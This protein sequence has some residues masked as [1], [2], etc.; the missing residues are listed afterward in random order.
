MRL[1]AAVRAKVKS[2]SS[3][4]LTLQTKGASNTMSVH[5]IV[6]ARWQTYSI[7][8]DVPPSAVTLSLGGALIGDGEACFDDFR[9]EIVPPGIP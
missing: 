8:L 5:P 4:R 3:A 7:D 9:L 1:T 2:G 6:D